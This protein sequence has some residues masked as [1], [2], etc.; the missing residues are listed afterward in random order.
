M[1]NKQCNLLCR[2]DKIKTTN[3]IS[4]DKKAKQL[5]LT[6]NEMMEMQKGKASLIKSSIYL[7]YDPAVPLLGTYP[8]EFNG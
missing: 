5:K 4:T 3:N 2:K 8:R 1:Q 7:P 6:Y